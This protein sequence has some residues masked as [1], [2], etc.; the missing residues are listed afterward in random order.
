MSKDARKPRDAAIACTF[1]LRRLLIC[2][3]LIFSV[4]G[5]T[6][7]SG[8]AL[9]DD[10]GFFGGTAVVPTYGAHPAPECVCGSGPGDSYT[11]NLSGSFTSASNWDA[12]GQV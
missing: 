4:A 5:L 3:V 2:F 9:A 12:S 7:G 10:F 8:A 11:Y 6:V 1:N